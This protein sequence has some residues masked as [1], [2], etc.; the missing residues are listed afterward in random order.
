MEDFKIIYKILKALHDAMDFEEF[1]H[2]AI[3][4][5]V[6]GITQA[7]WNVLMAML[8]KNGYVEDVALTPILGRQVVASLGRRPQITL[9]GLEYLEENSMMKKAAKAAKG[10]IDVLT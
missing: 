2:E 7:R 4:P 10:I 1:S 3:S 5:E 8:V 9:K 6:L